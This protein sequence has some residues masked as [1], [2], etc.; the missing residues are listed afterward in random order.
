MIY[1]VGIDINSK[2]R[3]KIPKHIKKKEKKM[4]NSD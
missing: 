1:H 4:S 3:F 2:L